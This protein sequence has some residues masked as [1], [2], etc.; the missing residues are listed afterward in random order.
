MCASCTTGLVNAHQLEEESMNRSRTRTAA[1]AAPAST[2]A[3]VRANRVP[4]GSRTV[5]R[6]SVVGAVMLGLGAVAGPAS[7]D[8]PHV[9]QTPGTCVDKAGAGFGTD[10]DHSAVI[11]PQHPSLTEPSFHTRVHWGTP[12]EFAFEREDHP[13]SIVG[14]TLCP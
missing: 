9:I 14:K 11:E 7:A 8:H 2:S 13:V 5:V 12:G 10:Q 1:S 3:A 6:T 4:G